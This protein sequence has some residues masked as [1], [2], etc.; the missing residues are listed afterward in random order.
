[1]KGAVIAGWGT[2]LPDKVVTNA[3]LEARLDTTDAWITERFGPGWG[4]NPLAMTVAEQDPNLAYGTDLGRAMRTTDGGATW[5]ALYSRKVNDAGW[6]T[7]GLDVTNINDPNQTLGKLSSI[8]IDSRTGQA[9][10]AVIDRGGVLGWDR[11]HV[12]VPFSLLKFFGQW[13]RPSLNMDAFKLE[14]GPHVADDPVVFD[15]LVSH[16]IADSPQADESIF[17]S[18]ITATTK[19]KMGELRM[20]FAISASECVPS[21]F[22]V[23]RCTILSGIVTAGF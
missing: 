4:E 9:R 17:F 6:T 18:V 14:N 11:H 10:F 22:T 5:A 3:D 20:I 19:N 2:A 16:R 8:I 15:G 13:D 23:F 21:I 1:L 12:I 7:L